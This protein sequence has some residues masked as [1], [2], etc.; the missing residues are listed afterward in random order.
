MEEEQKGRSTMMDI[1]H[2]YAVT[3]G[4]SAGNHNFAPLMQ[5]LIKA[6]KEISIQVNV[7]PAGVPDVNVAAPSVTVQSATPDIT[8]Q[9]P[10]GLPPPEAPVVIPEHSNLLASGLCF[11]IFIDVCLKLWEIYHA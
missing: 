11:F 4:P 7:P 2:G 5:E 8:V 6:V 10:Q 9:A 1:A 3:A